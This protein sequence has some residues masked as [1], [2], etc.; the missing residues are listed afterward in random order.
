MLFGFRANAFDRMGISKDE[1]QLFMDQQWCLLKDVFTKFRKV[2]SRLGVC[3]KILI[4]A[5]T[6][7]TSL[8][9]GSLDMATRKD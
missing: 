8:C 1:P 6:K 7:L 3:I 4:F 2:N 5:K 9:T